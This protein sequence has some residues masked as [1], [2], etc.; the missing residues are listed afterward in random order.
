MVRGCASLSFCSMQMALLF[1]EDGH[2]K[3]ELKSKPEIRSDLK[4]GIDVLRGSGIVNNTLTTH[5]V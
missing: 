1:R 4:F 2:V 5:E 3:Q